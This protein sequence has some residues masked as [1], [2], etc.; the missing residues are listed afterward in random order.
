[1]KRDIIIVVEGG[2]M[3]VGFGI[4]AL[5]SL[6]KEHI[7][8]RIHSLYGSSAGAHDVAYFLG[9]QSHLG[10]EVPIEYLNKNKFIKKKKIFKFIKSL[11]LGKKYN[12]MNIDY[13]INIEKHINR[14]NIHSVKNSPIKLYFRVFNIDSLE[15]E[16]IDGKKHLFDGLKASSTCI[17]Y[18]NDLVRINNNPYIDGSYMVTQPFEEIVRKNPDKKI[19]YIVNYKQNFAKKLKGYPVRVMESFLISRLFGPKLALKYATT[20]DFINLEK[21][22]K[23]KNIILVVNNF[24]DDFVCTDRDELTKLYN[25]GK[26]QG[27]IAASL[28]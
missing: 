17:P 5:E 27:E 6:Q 12:L 26:E 10:G 22:K 7:Y 14:L 21:L 3:T 18:F 8:S 9:K 13:L 20:F 11:I 2:G 15:S 4:G 1:M 16:I 24:N 19:I 23:H 28:I 25:Y